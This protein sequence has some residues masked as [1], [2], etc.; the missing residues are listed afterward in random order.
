[1]QAPGGNQTRCAESFNKGKS[2]MDLT[3]W[4]DTV[5]KTSVTL[6]RVCGAKVGAAA[7]EGR[8]A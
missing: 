2:A 3:D 8:R 1:M 5:S 4:L 6:L 7:A